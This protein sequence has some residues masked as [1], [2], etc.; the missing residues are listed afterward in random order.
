MDTCFLAL[1]VAE[2]LQVFV[3]TILRKQ[4][5]IRLLQS[6]FPAIIE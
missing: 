2:I 5:A 6:Q 4:S 1:A 3:T